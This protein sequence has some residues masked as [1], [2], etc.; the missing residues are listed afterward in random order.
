MR[1]AVLCTLSTGLFAIEQATSLGVKINKVIGLNP[2]IYRNNMLISGFTD[3]KSFCEEN[4]L[5]YSYVD[6]YTLSTEDPVALLNDIDLLWVAGWQRLIPESFI[7]VPKFGAIG[8]HGSCD[9]ITKGRGRSP[10]NW[11]LLIGA[12]SF[13]IS[14]FKISSGIDDGA[15]IATDTFNLDNTDNILTSYIKCALSI[16]KCISA[17][18]KKPSIIEQ[19]SQQNGLS[20]Y[21]PKRTPR[22]GAID[23]NMSVNDI[24]NQIRALTDPYPNARTFIDDI[25]VLI[26]RSTPIL[27]DIDSEPG[28][29]MSKLSNG[30]LLV[31]AKN[32]YV[33]IEDYQFQSE[34]KKLSPGMKLKSESMN[35]TVYRITSRFKTEFPGKSLNTSLIEF[36]RRIGVTI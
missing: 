11:A 28:Y 30:E 22:D 21:F 24:H 2:N 6:D 23:W 10:Q 33:L 1:I 12:K 5:S 3:I 15:I 29:I 35:S 20:Q 16:A 17:I 8:G 26:K 32:G 14:M 4:Q 31:C 19:A 25:Q 27:C 36:W 34:Y 18:Y 9:G 13:E 7:I